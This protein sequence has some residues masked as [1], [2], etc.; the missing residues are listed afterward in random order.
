MAEKGVRK[1]DEA[2]TEDRRSQ[3]DWLQMRGLDVHFHKGKSSAPQTLR[4]R[5][6][7]RLIG[8]VEFD[9]LVAAERARTAPPA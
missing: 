6:G 9:A 4:W 1:C 2:E 3:L 7:D 8:A 5:Y